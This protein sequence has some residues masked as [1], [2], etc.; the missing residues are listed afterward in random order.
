MIKYHSETTINQPVDR[1][2]RSFVDFEN[3]SLWTDMGDTRLI[4]EGNVGV[5]SKIQTEMKMGPMKLKLVFEITDYAVNRSVTF[6][7]ISKGPL[8][9][10]AYNTFEAKGARAT[11]MTYSGELHLRGLL[12][13]M[14]PLMAGEVQSQETKELLT[15]KGLLEAAA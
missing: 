6:K 15:F 4:T 12:R 5:G 2:F 14:E 9:W 1:V 7:T 11:H 13:L 8:A 3:M 10:V